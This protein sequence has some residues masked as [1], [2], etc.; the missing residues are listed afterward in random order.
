[1]RPRAQAVERAAAEA[2]PVKAVRQGGLE[3]LKVLQARMR[4]DKF[5]DEHEKWPSAA[6]IAS[7]VNYASA[8]MGGQTYDANWLATNTTGIPPNVR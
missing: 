3:D 7:L 1:M 4:S 5:D 8:P 6:G 2:R